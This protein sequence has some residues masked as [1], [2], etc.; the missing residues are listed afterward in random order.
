MVVATL[1]KDAASAHFWENRT[2]LWVSCVF[3]QN[4]H[5]RKLGEI[6]VFLTMWAKTFSTPVFR[7]KRQ[8]LMTSSV[9]SPN[10]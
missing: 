4:S 1:W 8:F 5:T 9:M 3:P 7:K 6:A 2:K 10:F